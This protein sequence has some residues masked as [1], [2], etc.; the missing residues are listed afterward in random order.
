VGNVWTSLVKV[1]LLVVSDSITALS[2]RSVTV[3]ARFR[4]VSLTVVY[5]PMISGSL[6]LVILVSKFI[7]NIL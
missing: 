3:P 5:L 4:K 1:S 7:G 6:L 2:V